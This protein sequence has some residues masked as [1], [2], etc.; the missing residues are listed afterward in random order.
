M[1][2]APEPKC[3]SLFVFFYPRALNGG[4]AEMLSK[5]ASVSISVAFLLRMILKTF[6]FECTGVFLCAWCVFVGVKH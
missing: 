4:E 3:E 1:H 5:G 6:V 2:K